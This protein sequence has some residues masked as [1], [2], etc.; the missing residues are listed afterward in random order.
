MYRH[1][2]ARIDACYGPC[3]RMY[4]CRTQCVVYTWGKIMNGRT[5]AKK[6][7]NSIGLLMHIEMRRMT[8]LRHAPRV[9][10]Q[11]RSGWKRCTLCWIQVSD[12]GQRLEAQCMASI[13]KHVAGDYIFWDRNDYFVFRW[14]IICLESFSAPILSHE[15][16]G[17]RTTWWRRMVFLFCIQNN[18]SILCTP[19]S[20]KWCG[21]ILANKLKFMLPRSSYPYGNNDHQ[22]RVVCLAGSAAWSTLSVWLPCKLRRCIPSDCSPSRCV[23]KGVC[24]SI[25]KLNMKRSSAGSRW[26]RQSSRMDIF[27][28]IGPMNKCSDFFHFF[29]EAAP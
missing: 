14:Y 23:S 12:V 10:F 24:F 25:Q 11:S 1:P 19:W 21:D 8:F 26:Q 22:L 5:I 29:I 16:L 28:D 7:K 4:Q 20:A 15:V 27:G 13:T 3:V 6:G 2:S 17:S 9:H 18:T